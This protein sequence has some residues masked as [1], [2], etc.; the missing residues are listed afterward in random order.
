MER[1]TQMRLGQERVE[2]LQT[3]T[4]KKHLN[5]PQLQESLLQLLISS[6]IGNISISPLV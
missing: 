6:W 1:L 5:G 4:G 3:Q 2:H